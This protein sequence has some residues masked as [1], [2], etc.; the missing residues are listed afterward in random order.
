[1][2]GSHGPAAQGCHRR[3]AGLGYRGRRARGDLRRATHHGDRRR[4]VLMEFKMR[5]QATAAGRRQGRRGG[6]AADLARRA[7]RR[8]PDERRRMSAAGERDRRT[9][10]RADEWQ[11]D[12]WDDPDV[13]ERWS[14]SAP[15]RSSSAVKCRRLRRRDAWRSPACSSPVAS[16]CGTSARSTRRATRARSNFT[17]RR[18]RHLESVSDRL[19]DAGLHQQ[20][21]RVPL[22]RRAATAGSS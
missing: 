20:R 14:S 17:V 18:R 1:M 5:A 15:R 11:H 7:R 21:R 9:T 4:S 10:C 3:S 19:Q 22:V 6:D 8:S 2:N 12:P 13:T 16:G